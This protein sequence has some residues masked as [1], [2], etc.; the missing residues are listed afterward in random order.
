MMTETTLLTPEL[1]GIGCFEG[2]EALYP[3]H[4]LADA[5]KKLV[6]TKTITEETSFAEI[7]TQLAVEVMKELTYPDFKSL[8]GYLFA[9]RRHKPSIRAESLALTPELFHLLQEKPE[10]YFN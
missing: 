5:I 10:A 9:Y 3:I 4:V 6:L 8:R 2:I 1:Y 7:R